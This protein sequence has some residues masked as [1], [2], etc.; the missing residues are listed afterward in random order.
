MKMKAS[1]L[2]VGYYYVSYNYSMCIQQFIVN[3]HQTKH[4]IK[5]LQQKAVVGRVQQGQRISF[6]KDFGWL[7]VYGNTFV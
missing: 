1:N 5:L 4:L 2:N 6:L 3:T 7:T